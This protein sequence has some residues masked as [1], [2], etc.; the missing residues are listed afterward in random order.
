MT[1]A[2]T[3]P[4]EPLLRPAMEDLRVNAGLCGL[5]ELEWMRLLDEAVL[6]DLAVDAPIYQPGSLITEVVFPVDCVLSVVT[7]MRDGNMIEVGTI[8]REGN[9]GIPLL[10]GASTTA[11]E[12]YCQV[13][14]RA[15]KV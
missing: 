7:R 14:G 8:G 2:S 13:P 9:S 5:S 3:R 4:T 10:L 11:N 12:C 1:K 6:V 15:I